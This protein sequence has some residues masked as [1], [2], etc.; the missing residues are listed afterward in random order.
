MGVMTFHTPSA[1]AFVYVRR[2]LASLH[3]RARTCHTQAK[4]PPYNIRHAVAACRRGS[5]AYSCFLITC[6]VCPTPTQEHRRHT[7]RCCRH[8]RALTSH[9]SCPTAPFAATVVVC[10][11][12][13]PSNQSAVH[14]ST[15]ESRTR[16][17]RPLHVLTISLPAMCCCGFCVFEHRSNSVTLPSPSLFTAS[18]RAQTFQHVC[19]RS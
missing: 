2:A 6:D 16:S 4:D 17:L 14:R 12:R 10:C 13:R 19:R 11:R 7:H 3:M 15:D 8:A 5:V 18:P 1:C 9:N